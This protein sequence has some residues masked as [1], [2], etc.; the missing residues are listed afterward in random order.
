MKILLSVVLI[1]ILSFFAGLYFP[2]WSIAIVAFIISLL[3]PQR[4]AVSF[5]AG[6]A[7]VFLLWCLLA[8][9]INAANNS[10]LA[11]RIGSML[12]IGTNAGLLIFIVSFVGGLVG[13]L[14]ALSASYLHKKQ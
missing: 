13:G 12:G 3:I 11:N 5:L 8:Y 2:W 14:A 7:G 9:F 1:A 6:F 4:P 10:V